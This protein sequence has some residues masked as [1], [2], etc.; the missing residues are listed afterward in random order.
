M[1]EHLLEVINWQLLQYPVFDFLSFFLA[2]GCFFESDR[3]ISKP[4]SLGDLG[5]FSPPNTLTRVSM[6]HVLNLRKY[7]EFFTDFAVQVSQLVQVNGL[8]LV[9]SILALARKHLNC[10]VI[11]P[12]EMA[13]LTF[14]P[15]NK[16]HDVFYL[17]ELKYDESFPEHAQSQRKHVRDQQVLTRSLPPS[18]DSKAAKVSQTPIDVSSAKTQPQTTATHSAS[19]TTQGSKY[20]THVPTTQTSG[21]GG[22]GACSISQSS[23]ISS[24]QK[25][26]KPNKPKT[27]L[28]LLGAD[29]PVR[30]NITQHFEA[31]AR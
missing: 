12:T 14:T 28:D 2:Q 15:L 30:A 31:A 10:E 20:H 26:A 21:G 4:S 6:Q 11:W 18:A 1:E 8:V 23:Y 9:T 5:S 17:L 27:S 7:G 25:E 29:D 13:L 22:G 16:F 24:L 3:I 19:T